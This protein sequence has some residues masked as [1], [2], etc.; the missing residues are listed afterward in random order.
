MPA[1]PTVAW[2]FPRDEKMCSVAVVGDEE[3]EWCGLGWTGQPAVFEREGHTW[4]V[5]GALDGKVHFLDGITG[6]RRLPDLPTGDLSLI[7][8]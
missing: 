2:R 5:F 4:V 8:I 1:A 3:K 7:H 6:A